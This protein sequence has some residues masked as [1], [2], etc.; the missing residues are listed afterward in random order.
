[1]RELGEVK[2]ERSSE[3]AS[4]LPEVMESLACWEA[5]VQQRCREVMKETI[6]AGLMTL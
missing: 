2:L 5:V 6:A 1:M 4:G 3:M